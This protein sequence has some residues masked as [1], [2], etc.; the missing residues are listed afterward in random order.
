VEAGQCRRKLPAIHHR[1]P[2]I[3]QHETY[4]FVGAT[5]QEVEGMSTIWSLEDGIPLILQQATYDAPQAGL[6]LDDQ[7]RVSGWRDGASTIHCE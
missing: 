1:H 4:P 2:Q 7:Y 5:G 6:I 3:G